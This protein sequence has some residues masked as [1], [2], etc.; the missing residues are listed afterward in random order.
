LA[1]AVFDPHDWRQSSTLVPSSDRRGSVSSVSSFE[2]R[3]FDEREIRTTNQEPDLSSPLAWRS[4]VNEYS[5][6]QFLEERVQQEPVFK[7]QLLDYI[8]YSKVDRKWRTAASNAITILVRA[9]VEFR[10]VN[11]QGIQ[12]PGADLTHGV[13]DSVNLQGADLRKANLRDISL[14]RSDLTGARMTGTEFGE[15]PFLKINQDVLS[16]M[17]SPDGSSFAVVFSRN[18]S[19]Y[20]YGTLNWERTWVLSGHDQEIS[21]IAYS[22]SG[23]RI[24][25]GSQDSTVRVWDTAT[26]DC[27][28]IF[29]GHT[30][31]VG[32]VVYAPQGK[33]VASWSDDQMIRLWDVEAGYCRSIISG[34]GAIFDVAFSLKEDIIAFGGEDCRVRL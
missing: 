19:I 33:V 7:Q 17:F 34:C 23:N 11:L 12:I 16:C 8:E 29:I 6:V 9:G 22:P 5:L 4:F 28:F 2:I 20:V 30:R 21:S 3:V 25:S 31:K 27:L 1:L 26:G 32:G 15:L 10:W 18:A 14:R 13:F 24:V